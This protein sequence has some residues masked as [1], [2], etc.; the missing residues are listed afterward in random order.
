MAEHNEFGKEGEDAAVAYLQS[1]GYLIRARNWR[2]GKFEIDIVAENEEY[3]VIVEVRS[4]RDNFLLHPIE[5]VGSR[6][7]KNIINAAECYIFSNNILKETR[8]DII[9]VVDS[10]GKTQIEHI[11]DAFLP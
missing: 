1:K 8:F 2:Q 7:I 6:K 4:R 5:S 9:S 11:E 3:L 10:G